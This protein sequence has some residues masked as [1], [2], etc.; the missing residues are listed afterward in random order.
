M[1]YVTV[2]KVL[3]GTN[4]AFD[5]GEHTLEYIPGKWT[6]PSVGK[7]Y[8]FQDR[9]HALRWAVDYPG[10][11]VWEAEAEIFT[12]GNCLMCTDSDYS[13]CDF[14]KWYLPSLN[15]KAD[16]CPSCLSTAYTANGTVLCNKLILT[17]KVKDL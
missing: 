15:E 7:I 3:K 12:D 13:L 6:Y 8:A 11:S 5:H 16:V 1:E 2:V 9:E 10:H 4:S 14:W 17:K